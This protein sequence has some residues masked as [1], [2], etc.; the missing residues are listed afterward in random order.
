MLAALSPARRRLALAIGSLAVVGLLVVAVLVV[1]QV[2]GARVD[3]VAQ[4]DPG[5]VLLV[6]GYGGSTER[7]EPLA[8]ILEQAGRDVTVVDPAGDGTG[9]LGDQAD[10][11]GA[12]ADAALIRTGAGSVDV[13]GYSAGGI[14]ARLWV[15]DLGGA[16][17]ARRVLTLGSPNHGTDVAGIAS[18]L[19]PAGCPAACQQLT[20][21]SELIRRLNAGDETPDGPVFVAVWTTLDEIV[22]PPDSARLDGALNVTVQSVCPGSQVLHGGL[23]EDPAVAAILAASLGVDA[24]AVPEQC[25]V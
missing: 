3:P 13:V 6:P 25:P 11:L 17:Q 12:A 24:P 15:R 1:R 18:E 4:D 20:P 2:L 8:A 5:P 16:S 7:L 23:P 9:D 10:V 21:S 14:V 19:V 22:T